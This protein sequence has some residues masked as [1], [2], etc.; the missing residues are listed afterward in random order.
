MSMQTLRLDY[1]ADARN[2]WAGA[3]MLVA[4]L[5]VLLFI[6]WSYQEQEQKLTQQEMLLDSMKSASSSRVE[7]LPA[8]KDTEQVALEIKQA[9]AV[10]LQLNL[11][12]KELF[13][14]FESAQHADVAVLAIEPDAQKGLVRISAEAKSLDS[15]PAYLAYLQKVPLF[16]EVALLNH[17]V[18]EQDP[19]RPVRFML[20]ATWGARR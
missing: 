14:A 6:V 2:P 13:E 7:I 3:A 17:Q 11:P 8:R 20:Q 16:Q 15:L 18:Q 4:G 9:N 1:Q 10:I 19:Q 12:W 5:A